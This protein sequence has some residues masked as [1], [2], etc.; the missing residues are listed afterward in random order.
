MAMAGVILI[1]QPEALFGGGGGGGGGG[2]STNRTDPTAPLPEKDGDGN[3]GAGIGFAF[4]GAVVAGLLPVCVRASKGA[5]WATVEHV[6]AAWAASILTPLGLGVQA[7]TGIGADELSRAEVVPKLPLIL[8]TAL[9]GFSALALQTIGYQREKASRASVMTFLE[10]PFAFMLQAV[11]FKQEPNVVAGA[12]IALVM[13]AGILNV[14]FADL[15]KVVSRRVT[16]GRRRKD[17]RSP[18]ASNNDGNGRY[19]ETT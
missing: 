13:L 7:A 16:R 18:A 6:A 10:I 2:A 3:Y 15:A 14:V 17:N 19:F 8:L 5:H 11:V 4:A 9:V 12:G 1:V